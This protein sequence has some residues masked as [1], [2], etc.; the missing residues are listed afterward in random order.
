MTEHPMDAAIRQRLEGRRQELRAQIRERTGVAK[1]AEQAA[2]DA[3]LPAALAGRLTG[4]TPEALAAD[5]AR[6]AADLAAAP[7]GE[8]MDRLIRAQR[9]T[10]PADAER[11][12]GKP[13]PSTKETKS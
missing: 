7:P 5:A 4:H 12:F 10:S 9:P 6:L 1:A 3:G 11:I 8:G 13:A 2:R